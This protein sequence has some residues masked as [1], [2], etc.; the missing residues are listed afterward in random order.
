MPPTE[1]AAPIF[2]PAHAPTFTQAA[3][4]FVVSFAAL[5][6]LSLLLAGL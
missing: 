4:R 2:A 6:G 1:V 5:I 3:M